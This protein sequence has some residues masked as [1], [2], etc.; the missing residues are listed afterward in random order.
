[1]SLHV[2][3]VQNNP[4]STEYVY[5]CYYLK[6]V[7]ST[8][9]PRT[10]ALTLIE[11][12]DDVEFSD[13][14]SDRKGLD[15]ATVTRDVMRVTPILVTVRRLR[16]RKET[17]LWVNWELDFQRYAISAYRSLREAGRLAKVTG[18]F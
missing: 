15:I 11:K 2:D 10:R 13:H 6:L 1:M 3:E 18:T 8:Y 16:S 17:L 12:Q 9:E 5:K 7:G 14:E 4:Q